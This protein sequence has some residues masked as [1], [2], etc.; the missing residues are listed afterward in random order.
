MTRGALTLS[1]HLMPNA[2]RVLVC[3]CVKPTKPVLPYDHSGGLNLSASGCF[4][5]KL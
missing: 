1:R 3:S 4:T 2:I 5:L